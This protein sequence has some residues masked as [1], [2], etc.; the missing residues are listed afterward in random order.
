ML[1]FVVV[2]T[3]FWGIVTMPYDGN[4]YITP[5]TKIYINK[6]IIGNNGDTLRLGNLLVQIDW[7][8][9]QN[10][11]DINHYFSNHNYTDN[12]KLHYIDIT[13]NGEFSVKQFETKIKNIP[14]E[15]FEYL[16]SMAL[17]VKVDEGGVSDKAGMKVGDLIVRFDDTEFNNGT[18]LHQR[19]ME[20]ESGESIYYDILRKN[21]FKTI[22]VQVV[23]FGIKISLLYSYVNVILLYLLALFFILKSKRQYQPVFVGIILALYAISLIAFNVLAP[24]STVSTERYLH[25]HFVV[26]LMLASVSLSIPLLLFLLLI[27]PEKNEN[28]GK[29]KWH[30]VGIFTIKIIV[31]LFLFT[32][33]FR[34]NLDVFVVSL[35]ILLDSVIVLYFFVLVFFYHLRAIKL[36]GRASKP[37]FFAIVIFWLVSFIDGIIS[38]FYPKLNMGYQIS[39]WIAPLITVTVVSSVFKYQP[40]GIIFRIRR[41]IQYYFLLYLWRLFALILTLVFLYVISLPNF[42]IPNLH[43][44]GQTIEVLNGPLRPELYK[45]YSKLLVLLIFAIF[46][47]LLRK[48]NKKLQNLF[49]KRFNRVKINYKLNS[50]ELNTLLVSKH[51]ID[52]IAKGFLQKVAEYIQVDS[53]A[54]MILNDYKVVSEHF[55]GISE[56]NELKLFFKSVTTN[57]LLKN[58]ANDGIIKVDNLQEEIKEVFLQCRLEIIFPIRSGKRAMGFLF[59]GKKNSDD[60][61]SNDE[62][63]YLE[64]ILNQLSVVV[65]KMFLNIK[66]EETKRIQQE[67]E[68]A[69]NIQLNSLPQKKP[70]IKNL[71]LAGLSIPALEVGGDFYD[72]LHKDEGSV[73]LLVGDVSGKGTSS[74]LYMS[75]IQGILRTLYQFNL[76]PKDILVKSN[77]LI[78]EG[79]N[80]GYFISAIL[81]QVN[82]LTGQ[83]VLAR[84]GH[85]PLYLYRYKTKKIE[86]YLPNGIVLGI[87]K[88]NL[89]EQCLEEFEFHLEENDVIL[90]VSDGVTEAR[91]ERGQEFEERGLLQVFQKVAEEEATQIRDYIYSEVQKFSGTVNQFDDITVLVA[92]YLPNSK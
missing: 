62:K 29:I 69:R 47:F 12:V 83:M 23:K 61:F 66:V 79:I 36:I 90:L 24:M 5:N 3:N 27:F 60:D 51:T 73:T 71:D 68:F 77:Q 43:F 53:A 50:E 15:T 86:K 67:L 70:F 45:V 59:L 1:C 88:S 64:T 39:F 92:R 48:L 14:K 46:V 31:F 52:E 55:I 74:A 41:N 56:T 13:S 21:E 32:L 54:I 91:D 87:T 84:A 25:S 11:D 20:K 37:L 38:T 8:V 4:Q 35:G 10:A 85:L 2:V 17:V 26:G 44:T 40:Y 82:A 33:S 65:E 34:G 57:E 28:M 75:K 9:V 63:K 72:Y 30:F 22:K 19:T 18:Q 58:Y 76:S 80:K 42:Y 6:D 78:S 16:S 89:F 7:F 81:L 49:D